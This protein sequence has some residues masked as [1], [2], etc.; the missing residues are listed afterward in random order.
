[1]KLVDSYRLAKGNL[2]RTRTRSFLTISGVIV[3]ISS[4]VLLVSLAIG[5]QK[6]SINKIASINA[7]TRLT[8]M[9]RESSSPKID[10]AMVERLS[11]LQNIEYVSPQIQYPARITLLETQSDVLAVGIE[12]DRLAFN[13]IVINNGQNFSSNKANEAIVSTAVL[14]LFGKD[15]DPTG[16]IGKEINFQLVMPNYDNSDVTSNEISAKIIGTTTDE[17][18]SNVY[19][20][21]DLLRFN[22]NSY[23]SAS[24]KV[25]NRSYMNITKE[26]VEKLGLQTTTVSDL[27]D[28]IDQAFLYFK[29]ILSAIGGIALFVAAIGIINTM[30]ISLLERTH[31]IGIM[32]ALGAK[33]S[34]IRKIFLY[35]SAIIG[36][37]GGAMGIASG[38]L[39]GLLINGAVALIVRA[40]QINEEIILFVMSYQFAI[41]VLIFS[42][43]LAFCAGIYPAKRASRLSPLQALKYQ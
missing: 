9:P 14:K 3:S 34:D 30:T 4:I 6:L 15:N 23:N 31:E 25:S 27:I 16:V 28:Q 17:T 22:N 38:W 18:L 35:E 8:V 42:T 10:D 29:I 7:L 36:F 33:D 21:L 19:L 24:L 2:A 41:F 39:V 13:D 12:K 5:L 32:K 26:E 1:M 11:K 20:P 43:A 40:N 37:A